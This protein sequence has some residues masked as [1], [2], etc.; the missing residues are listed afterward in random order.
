MW[1]AHNKNIAVA[2]PS[3]FWTSCAHPTDS[4]AD[5]CLHIGY[6][7]GVGADG[8]SPNPPGA[9]H[10]ETLVARWLSKTVDKVTAAFADGFNMDVEIAA[11]SPTDIAALTSVTR[12]AVAA[13]HA[14]RPGSH[15]TFD[16]PSEGVLSNGCG[17]MYGRD[18]DYKSL[19]EAVDFL[20]VMDY[21]SGSPRDALYST[22]RWI[23]GDGNDPAGVYIYDNRSSATAACA[24]HGYQR[25]CTKA[26]LQ[27]HAVCGAG[28]CSDWEGYWMDTAKPG[29]G[30]A[31]YNNHSG[32]AGAFCCGSVPPCATCFFA[33]AALPVVKAGVQCYAT[34]GIPASKLVLA[35]PW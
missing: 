16:V 9:W 19:A 31:G 10:N 24:A 14:A 20:V 1:R 7:V 25:L 30:H 26:E 18:Y 12:R 13:M 5:G 15:V 4:P 34:L 27:G 22:F 32:P 17:H 8:P 11:A 23:A 33:N 2:P 6:T 28:W 21:D 3:L 29:C 35:F